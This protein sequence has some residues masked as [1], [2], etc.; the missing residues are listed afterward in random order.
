MTPLEQQ[1]RKRIDDTARSISGYPV[2]GGPHQ[3]IGTWKNDER[4]FSYKNGAH[5]LLPLLLEM[6]EALNDYAD[7]GIFMHHG[8]AKTANNA[9]ATLQAFANGVGEKE[10][11]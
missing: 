4:Y 10:G 2:N 8:E 11:K 9:I 1:L 5:S 7:N 3:T 6:A